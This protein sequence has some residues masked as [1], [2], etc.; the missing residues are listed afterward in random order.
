MTSKTQTK[1]T[2]H[3]PSINSRSFSN[4]GYFMI[5]ESSNKKV[6]SRKNI[7]EL[8]ESRNRGKWDGS[9]N[10]DTVSDSEEN[11]LNKAMA[12]TAKSR[13]DKEEAFLNQ[14]KDVESNIFLSS[15][16]GKLVRDLTSSDVE[17]MAESINKL[18]GDAQGAYDTC[19]DQINT[20]YAVVKESILDDKAV[21][22]NHL[23]ARLSDQDKLAKEKQK[24]EDKYR[25]LEQENLAES[26]RFKG[27][28]RAGVTRQDVKL[29][30]MDESNKESVDLY[31]SELKQTYT[32]GA[33]GGSSVTSLETHNPLDQGSKP[34]NNTSRINESQPSSSRIVQ[35]SRDVVAE[36]DPFDPYCEE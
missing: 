7:P 1:Q 10:P 5:D 32:K 2:L 14:N 36:Y 20:A 17:Y 11:T 12:T 6:P 13:H 26:N 33:S 4:T 35:D 24:V 28:L 29:R 9:T 27:E 30:G 18:E 15:K 21:E 16:S 22:M 19:H 3:F 25:E 23:E 31:E 34:D 8:V